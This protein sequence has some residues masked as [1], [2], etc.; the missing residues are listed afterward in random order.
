MDVI[1][2][3]M[4]AVRPKTRLRSLWASPWLKAAVL[5][6]CL[7]PLLVL[8][9][10]WWNEKL[11][12]N[13]VE[14]VARYTGIWTLRFLLLT[15]AITPLRRLPGLGN[16]IRFRRMLGLV[17]FF[18]ACLHGLHYFALDVQWNWQVIEEDLTVRRFFIAGAAALLLMVPLAATSFD[19]AI[20]W[21]GGRKWQLL[22]R[23]VYVSGV[24]GVVHYLWQGKSI[25]IA[26]VV[27]GAIL[28]VLLIA[29]VVFFLDK[30]RTQ[31][32]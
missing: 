22:H 8:A 18:Y 14:Y 31:R 6:L 15:L 19:G 1:V 26:P 27:Y 4:Q 29:R 17:T 21:M 28:L 2:D 12:W 23:L 20:R 16:L 24:L 3:A 25:V 7:T 9:W 11:G 32:P 5:L 30:R 13:R 10:L